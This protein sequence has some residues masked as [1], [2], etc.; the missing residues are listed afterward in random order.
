MWATGLAVLG[1]MV[2]AALIT[3]GSVW[4]ETEKIAQLLE[5]KSKLTAEVSALQEQVEQGRRN[6]GRRATGK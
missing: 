5:Q 4:L 1:M 6:G 2:A 3:M